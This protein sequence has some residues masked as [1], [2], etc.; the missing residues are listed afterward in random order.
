M[1]ADPTIRE[2]YCQFPTV[3]WVDADGVVHEHRFDYF[4]IYYDGTKRA[5]NVKHR[6][7]EAEVKVVFDALKGCDL[8]FE[9][10]WVNEDMATDGAAANARAILTARQNYNEEDYVDALL[11]LQGIHGGVYFYSLLNGAGNVAGPS[12]GPP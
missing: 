3:E 12:R 1:L 7:D 11:S 10:I 5:F 8:R 4:A 9:V 6:C 2:L